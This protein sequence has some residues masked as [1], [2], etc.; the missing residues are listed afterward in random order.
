MVVVGISFFL[1]FVDLAALLCRGMDTFV[2]YSV[3]H[4]LLSGSLISL[5]GIVLQVYYDL[6]NKY[7]Y[8]Y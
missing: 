8:T 5:R 1:G 7:S 6:G 4:G 3:F 2:A